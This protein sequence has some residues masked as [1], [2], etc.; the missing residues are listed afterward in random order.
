MGMAM[1]A[2]PRRGGVSADINVTPMAD[3][4]I[5]LL[6]IFMIAVPAMGRPPVPLP[7]ARHGREHH[8]DPVI[9]V[10]TAGGVITVGSTPMN[11]SA[12][13]EAYLR[14]RVDGAHGGLPVLVQADRTADYAKVARALDACRRA[15]VTEIGL[16]TRPPLGR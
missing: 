7:D 1:R 2:G 16:A 12:A 15:G 3:I 11:G 10:I 9:V 5:V 6:V 14:A 4:M 8:E 13:L